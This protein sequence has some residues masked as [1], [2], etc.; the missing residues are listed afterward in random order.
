[1]VNSIHNH[2]GNA[3]HHFS[4]LLGLTIHIVRILCGDIQKDVYQTFA[5]KP[6]TSFQGSDTVASLNSVGVLS[7]ELWWNV[8]LF[9]YVFYF[10]SFAIP[11]LV[12]Q[13]SQLCDTETW[14]WYLF[15]LFFSE[16]RDDPSHPST[17]LEWCPVLLL[18]SASG[19]FKIRQAYYTSIILQQ[20]EWSP[21]TIG[22]VKAEKSSGIKNVDHLQRWGTSDCLKHNGLSET[23]WSTGF[24]KGNKNQGFLWFSAGCCSNLHWPT[25]NP[26]VLVL[27]C[28]SL[29]VLRGKTLSATTV[30]SKQAWNKGLSG[31]MGI[32]GFGRQIW[33]TWD[34]SHQE[35][36]SNG[37]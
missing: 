3:F 5:P 18:R 33:D 34:F 10:R 20:H 36:N 17:T 6:S 13:S 35:W 21:K 24:L 19:F 8:F 26:Q 7:G 31:H 28:W 27:R 11:V 16:V 15:N 22:F 32:H 12:F 9:S 23:V 2:P 29:L 1:M 14:P 30:A 25:R 4:V 37:S